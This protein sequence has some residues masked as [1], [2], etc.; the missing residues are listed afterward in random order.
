MLNTWVDRP[1]RRDERAWLHLLLQRSL[2][3]CASFP[4]RS[5][6][7]SSLR[8]FEDLADQLSACVSCSAIG[9]DS[10]LSSAF[11]NRPF[12]RVDCDLT[13]LFLIL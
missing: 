13:I 4:F 1:V 11:P 3:R 8:S 10:T 12:L 5:L 6:L 2:Q 7:F 9:F